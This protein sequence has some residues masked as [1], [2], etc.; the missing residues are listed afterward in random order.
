MQ[1]L[2]Y[3]EDKADSLDIRKANRDAHLAFLKAGDGAQVLVAGPWLDEEGVMRGSML[4]VE[5]ESRENVET[6]L[7]HDPYAKAGLTEK[8]IIRHYKWVIGAPAA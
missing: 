7:S 6:W 1:F 4:I 5:S 2:I 3:A 8:V